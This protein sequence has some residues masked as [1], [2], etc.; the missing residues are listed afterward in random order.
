M[1]DKYVKAT[2]VGEYMLK[3]GAYPNVMSIN[4]F[5]SEVLPSAD[6]VPKSDYDK[7]KTLLDKT[8]KFS[9]NL[10][11][12][13]QEAN[14]KCCTLRE[15]KDKIK[16]ELDKAIGIIK[17]S[18]LICMACKNETYEHQEC[19]M[20]CDNCKSICILQKRTQGRQNIYAFS[21]KG[22]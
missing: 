14:L 13:F 8:I 6:V 5:V 16:A 2:T 18:D 10:H 12:A 7:L 11:D 9:Q 4:Q 20:D 15:E 19:N 17:R 3:Y 22:V 21:I 1:A